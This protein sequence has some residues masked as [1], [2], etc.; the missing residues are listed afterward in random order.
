MPS[1]TSPRRTA[2]VA[3]GRE[4]LVT[5]GR[6]FKALDL[7]VLFHQGKRTTITALIASEGQ[8]YR[9]LVKGSQA[10]IFWFFLIKWY[11]P[12][13]ASGQKEH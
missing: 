13:E 2:W 8:A 9:Q 6:G 5:V 1:E 12:T 3:S 11:I 7:L 4:D 10:L